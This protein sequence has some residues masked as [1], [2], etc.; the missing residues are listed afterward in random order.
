MYGGSELVQEVVKAPLKRWCFV[1]EP[2]VP[3]Y[4]MVIVLSDTGQ[5][6]DRFR[7]TGREF[8]R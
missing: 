6:Q 4:K 5:L 3:I 8:H 7:H 2:P 1:S